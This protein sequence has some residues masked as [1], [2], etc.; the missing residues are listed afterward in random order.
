M[1]EAS[2]ADR[3][4]LSDATRNRLEQELARVREQRRRLAD[5]LGGEDPDNPDLGDRGDEAFQLEGLDDLSRMDQRIAEIERLIAGPGAPNTPPG[6]ADGTIVTLRFSGGDE[7]TFRIVAIP[8]QA[9][10]DG[11]DDV[12]TVSSPLGQALVGRRAGDTVSYRGP[13]G[14]LQAEVVAVTGS[15]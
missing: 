7:A 8:E 14:D 12:V 5:Q 2:S 9:P 15:E 3:P 4:E 6:L 13:D 1:T 11:Q 10:A